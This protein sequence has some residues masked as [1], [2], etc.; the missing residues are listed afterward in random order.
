ME[1]ACKPFQEG[2]HYLAET[3]QKAI[4]YL[5]AN[6]KGRWIAGGNKPYSYAA[7][8]HLFTIFSNVSITSLKIRKSNYININN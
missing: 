2:I 4:H 7:I 6:S 3:L 8:H 1:T 5:V